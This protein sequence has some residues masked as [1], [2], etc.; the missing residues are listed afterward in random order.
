MRKLRRGGRGRAAV[1]VPNGTLFEGGVSARIKADLI[2]TCDLRAVI[3]LP[4]GVFAPYTNIPANILIFATGGPTRQ[5]AYWQQP[6]PEGRRSYT[7][8]QPMLDEELDDLLAWFRGGFP[9]D[10][11]AWTVP[12][13]GLVVKDEE[14]RVVACNLDL[15][16]PNAVAQ[17]DH[18]MP[19]EIIAAAIAQERTALRL[20]DEMRALVEELA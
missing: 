17:E 9:E 4:E 6:L 18:R 19:A 20:L 14:G 7:K 8:T 10:P 13:D 3:R 15:K 11:R 1:I 5:I 12:A 2:E 16:N